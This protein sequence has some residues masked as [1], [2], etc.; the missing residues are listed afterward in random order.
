MNKLLYIS[1]I[2]ITSLCLNTAFAQEAEVGL[3]ENPSIVN[4]IRENPSILKAGNRSSDTLELPFF[5]DFSSYDIFPADTTW[6]DRDAFINNGYPI[7]PPSIGVA[8]S[9][10]SVQAKLAP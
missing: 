3:N 10:E 8:M 1:I 2:A 7:L 4:H 9:V 6:A 5:D